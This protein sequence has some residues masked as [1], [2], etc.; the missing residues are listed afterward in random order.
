[1]TAIV[2][3]F[4]GIGKVLISLCQLVV[5]TVLDLVYMIGLLGDMLGNIPAY[6][7]WIP[8]AV[9][10]SIVVIFSFVILYKVLGRE[11]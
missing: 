9:A 6:F 11:G 2:D 3:F 10:S 8:P 1:M 5:Q 7:G 4:A